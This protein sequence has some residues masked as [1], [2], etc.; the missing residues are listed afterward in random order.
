MKDRT[1]FIILIGIIALAYILRVHGINY[2]SYGDEHFHV[3]NS[4]GLATGQLP[5]NFHRVAL[6]LFYGLFYAIGWVIGIFRNPHDFI[7]VYFS[8]MHVF[9]YVGRF[10]EVLTGTAGVVLLYLWGKKI[11][12]RTAGSA[13]LEGAG[14][15]N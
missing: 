2:Y 11:F 7:G 10:F 4:L 14:I 15:P 12:S 1:S 3:Y 13:K 9:Y 5:G 6:F 8:Q